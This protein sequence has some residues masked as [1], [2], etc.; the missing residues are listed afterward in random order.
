[1]RLVAVSQH[2]AGRFLDAVPSRAPF[3]MHTW[4]LR[5]AVQRRLGLPLLAA[6]A[7]AG[8][9]FS[10]GGKTFDAYGDVAVNDGAAGH[11]TRHWLVLRAVYDALRRAWGGRV[12][13]EPA[14][15]HWY[16]GHRPDLTLLAEELEAMDLKVFDPV[17]SDAGEVEERGAFVGFGNTRPRGREKVHGREARGVEGTS[18]D[19]RTGTGEVAALAG[20][21]AGAR[22]RGVGVRLL[23]VETFGGL[24]DELVELLKAAADVRED[25]LNA[26][27]YDETTWSA[28]SWTV[29]VEQR[30]SIATQRA[31]AKE[32]AQALG[33]AQAADPRGECC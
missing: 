8:T 6:A 12:A 2:G 33:L 23:L 31:V 24:G 26:A 28:R 15:Y 17:G 16:S 25:T 14:D 10:R 32:I 18:F 9:L 20:D 29:F 5:V 21:Y 27:E 4:C 30:I 13:Y 19:P 22:A 7:A 1:M 11:A 3:R